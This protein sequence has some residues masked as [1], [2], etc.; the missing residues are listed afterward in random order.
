LFQG[1]CAS[2]H[3]IENLRASV[4]GPADKRKEIEGFLEAHGDATEAE[5]RLILEYL[6]AEGGP[7]DPR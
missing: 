1:H 3:T 5:D 2:C 7:T 4:S 6:A